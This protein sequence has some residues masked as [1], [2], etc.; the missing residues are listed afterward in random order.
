[1]S[2]SDQ[3]LIEQV[4]Q[5]TKSTGIMPCIKLKKKDDFIT[6]AKAMYDGGARVIE[7]TMTTPGALEA[8][9]AISGEFKGRMYV[10]AGTVL[11]PATARE[12]ILHGGSLIV[13]PCVIPDVI[14]LCGR[15][16]VPVYSGAF[17]ATECFAAMR[18]GATMVKVFPGALGGA[19]YMTNLKMVFPQINLIPSGGIS[20]ENAAEFIK[21]GA[22]AVSGARAF[23]D[24]DNIREHGI[25]WVTEQV[26]AFISIIQKA[27]AELPELP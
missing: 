11:D 5:A 8:I 18:A 25:G 23:M 26:K 14:D 3:T 2:R 7:V 20:L 6:Y 10:A 27:K 16:S 21:C 13:N 17:T 1:M 22:C 4:V 19:K 24:M 15:Y 12:V 9:E